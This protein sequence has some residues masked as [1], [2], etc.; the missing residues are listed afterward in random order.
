M[1]TTQ[2]VVG[3][4]K[5]VVDVLEA[6]PVWILLLGLIW[7][8]LVVVWPDLRRHM[9]PS[10]PKSQRERIQ[11]L[12]QK[13]ESING[14]IAK[15]ASLETISY[16]LLGSIEKHSSLIGD[17]L[18][19][20]S[21]IRESHDERLQSIEK[22]FL[23]AKFVEL[24]RKI[25]E[26]QQRSERLLELFRLI[27]QCDDT[28]N[29]FH[30]IRNFYGQ[31]CLLNRPFSGWRNSSG[32]TDST[33]SPNIRDSEKWAQQLENHLR[34]CRGLGARQK[35]PIVSDHLS[36]LVATWSKRRDDTSGG[37]F[38]QLLQ[39]HQNGLWKLFNETKN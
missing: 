23:S 3:W 30:A 39:G 20:V 17:S 31:D 28:I 4:T 12:E 18:K 35:T 2:D 13:L 27:W 5:A 11:S 26:S 14:D 15:I 38:L 7:I 8:T 16:S 32:W 1:S 33:P 9:M 10:L 21:G 34:D 6:H 29:S 36:I 19:M 22:L 25:V 24:E 37:D